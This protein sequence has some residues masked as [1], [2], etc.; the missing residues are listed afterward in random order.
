MPLLT[1]TSALWK[2][3]SLFNSVIYTISV[4]YQTKIPNSTLLTAMR[5]GSMFGEYLSSQNGQ[6]NKPLRTACISLKHY[7]QV[8][9]THQVS[10]LATNQRQKERQRKLKTSVKQL[11][12]RTQ[13]KAWTAAI[14]YT[15]DSNII[16]FLP[17]KNTATTSHTS[18]LNAT[19]HAAAAWTSADTD[20]HLPHVPKLS[21][22]PHRCCYQSMGQTDRWTVTQTLHNILCGC[23]TNR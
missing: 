3:W 17:V 23:I 6:N 1:A 8:G 10:T 21:S 5:W 11:Q 12:F 16:C 13:Q 15:A 2:C 9:H 22:K 4:P 18:A 20:W 19:L 14:S 7:I